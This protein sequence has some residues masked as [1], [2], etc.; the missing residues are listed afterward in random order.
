MTIRRITIMLLA[1]EILLCA[2]AVRAQTSPA[3]GAQPPAGRAGASAQPVKVE[4]GLIQGTVEE[5][6]SVYRGIPYAAPP[7]G[8]LRWRPPQPAPK[9]EGVRAAD[10][11]GSW[12][13]MDGWVIPDDQYKLYQAGRYNDVPVLVGYNS[14]EGA[15]FGAPRSQEAYV[16]SVR[17]RYGQFADTLLAAYPGGEGP[18]AKT[19]RDLQRDSMFGWHTWSWA[20]LQ[21][22]TGKSKAFLYYFDQHPDHPADSPRAGFGAAHG[23]E[24]PFV[25]Q[26]LDLPNRPPATAE[27]KALAEMITTY[28]TNFAKTGDPNGAGLPKWPAYSDANPQ[29][30]HFAHTAQAGPVV[31]PEGLKTL[32]AYFAS[33]RAGVAD[34]P[35]GGAPQPEKQ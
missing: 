12:P 23:A 8:D 25:F 26:H 22:K 34:A 2:A 33:R 3:G 21:T 31:S 19:A 35:A 13:I 16:Q 7:L 6:L 30:M 17:Q 4:G 29:S 14:D 32:D 28:W 10:K 11:F 9:W 15:T 18:A 20:R 27:D 1:V 24:V 5:G